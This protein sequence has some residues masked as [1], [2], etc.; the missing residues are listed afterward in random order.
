MSH[1]QSCGNCGAFVSEDEHN[2]ECHRKAPH[3]QMAGMM[4]EQANDT[5][6]PWVAADDWCFEWV[7]E[8]EAETK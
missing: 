5:I 8:A 6:W 7:P 1:N 4:Q 3:C 2:G